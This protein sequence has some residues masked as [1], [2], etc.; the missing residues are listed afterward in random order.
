ME[1]PEH[2]PNEELWRLARDDAHLGGRK[3]KFSTQCAAFAAAYAGVQSNVIGLAFGISPQTVSYISGCLERDPE[4]YRYPI[5][6]EN[7][8]DATRPSR[9]EPHDHNARR[10][11]N[12]YRRYE[13]VAREF[14]ALGS[15]EFTNRYMTP[16]N[17]EKIKSAR[18]RLADMKRLGTWGNKRAHKDG[19]PVKDG[20]PDFERMSNEQ[21][22]AWRHA[23]PQKYRAM[24]PEHFE[25]GNNGFY[26]DN[27]PIDK[28]RN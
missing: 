7:D 2:N 23:N 21:T 3:L 17:L 16:H 25:N 28:D 9:P 22:L 5:A 8:D 24:F 6:K 18:R 1:N 19:F 4:P 13:A 15:V 20:L 27:R 26:G 12:R 14:E 10:N 11:P